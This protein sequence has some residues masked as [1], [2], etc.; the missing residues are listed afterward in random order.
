MNIIPTADA[1]PCIV[2][3]GELHPFGIAAE[4]KTRRGVGARCTIADA[5]ARPGFK[6]RTEVF[7][8]AAIHDGARRADFNADAVIGA[9]EAVLDE[10]FV[11][12]GHARAERACDAN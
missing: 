11:A 3:G 4:R 5:R 1:A 12:E 9:R 10:S 2:G 8:R 7:A 6:T